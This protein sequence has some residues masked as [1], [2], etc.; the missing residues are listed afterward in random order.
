MPKRH[1][2]KKTIFRDQI[3]RVLGLR[4]ENA[5]SNSAPNFSETN[6][7][8]WFRAFS[9]FFLGRPKNAKN[10]S[11]RESYY[12]RSFSR[13][14]FLYIFPFF[15][16]NFHLAPLAHSNLR[17]VLK[18]L[19]LWCFPVFSVQKFSVSP[20]HPRTIFSLSFWFL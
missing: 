4:P 12:P 13:G 2:N 8:K 14:G 11:S 17:T 15:W 18:S 7:L 20:H 6:I 19:F 1:A 5:L 9:T 3:P 16:S 10:A